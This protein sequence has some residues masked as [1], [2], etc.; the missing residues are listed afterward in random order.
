LALLFLLSGCASRTP[1]PAPPPTSTVPAT[2]A[3]TAPAADPV[4][5]VRAECIQGRRRIGGRVLQV[6]SGGLVVDSGYAALFAPPFNHSWVAGGNISISRDPVAIEGNDPAAL[7]I[8]LVFLTDLPRSPKPKQ[9][10]YVIIVGYPAGQYTYTPVPGV[11][12]PI[13]QFS[14]GLETAVRLSLQP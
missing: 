8:G 14:A 4:E 7:A 6:A 3:Q 13:R 1:A 5:A 11:Q 9:Y 10:D 2:T 12:K